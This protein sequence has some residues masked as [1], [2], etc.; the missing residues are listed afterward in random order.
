MGFRRAMEIKECFEELSI[1]HRWRSARLRMLGRGH[2]RL[3]SFPHLIA[4]EFAHG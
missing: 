4:D 3:Q 2:R 1:R